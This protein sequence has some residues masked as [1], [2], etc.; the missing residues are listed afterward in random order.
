MKKLTFYDLFLL[1]AI[2]LFSGSKSIYTSIILMCASI[3]ELIDV[4]PKIVRLIK[5]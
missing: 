1:C 5:K 4:V 3:L 2:I